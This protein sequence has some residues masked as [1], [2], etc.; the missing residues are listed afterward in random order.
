MHRFNEI[1]VL[2]TS[3]RIPGIVSATNVLWTA[4]TH[5]PLLKKQVCAGWIRTR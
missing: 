1:G 2:Y 5:G 3:A 4:S